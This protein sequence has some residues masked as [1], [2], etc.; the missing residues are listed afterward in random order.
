MSSHPTHCA[1]CSKLTPENSCE[2]WLRV[3]KETEITNET[4]SA[5]RTCGWKDGAVF[6]TRR[7]KKHSAS[8]GDYATALEGK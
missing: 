4:L 3:T 5:C 1:D 2:I 8:T 6:F 7:A